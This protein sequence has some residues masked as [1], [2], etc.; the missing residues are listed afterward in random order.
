MGPD[1]NV[2]RWFVE[3]LGEPQAIDWTWCGGETLRLGPDWVVEI[4]HAPGHS[5][6]HLTIFDPRS[7]T[8]LMGDAVHGGIAPDTSG[9]LT[10]PTYTELEPYLASI[11]TL[12][13]LG[14]ETLAGCH[15]PI[16]RGA[17]IEAFLAA[18]REYA[19][20]LD[21][22]LVEELGRHSEG[23]TLRELIHAVGPQLTGGAPVWELELAY[24]FAA[25]MGSLVTRGEVR[26]DTTAAPTRYFV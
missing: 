2:R 12:R 26:A 5:P 11:E 10:F 4:H 21:D 16:L 9:K 7:R 23:A 19:Q 24:T 25:N 8:A 6:G 14:A 3:M 18:S 13:A 20:Q 1:E 17:E 15:W 22:A